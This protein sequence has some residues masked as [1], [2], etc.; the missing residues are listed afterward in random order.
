L[1]FRGEAGRATGW[2]SRAHRLLDREE[3]PCVE[4]G[5]LLLPAAEHKL[6]SG[7]A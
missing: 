6:L 5:Y 7:A 1:A 2:F 3:K 4:E